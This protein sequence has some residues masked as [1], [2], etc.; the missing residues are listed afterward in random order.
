MKALAFPWFEVNARSLCT[1]GSLNAIKAGKPD[2]AVELGLCFKVLSA[3]F[4]YRT[5]GVVPSPFGDREL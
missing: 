2:R 1:K 4:R 5:S 3:V